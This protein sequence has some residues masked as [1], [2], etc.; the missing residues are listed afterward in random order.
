MRPRDCPDPRF[1]QSRVHLLIFAY[2]NPPL[3]IRKTEIGIAADSM[4][5]GDLTVGPGEQIA[6]VIGIEQAA[7]GEPTQHAAAYLLCHRSHRF[8][9]QCGLRGLDLSHGHKSRPVPWLVCL[10]CALLALPDD[11]ILRTRLA[12]SPPGCRSWPRGLSEYR[13]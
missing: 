8:W 6:G 3:G 4:R 7:A 9:R 13:Q 10:S 12:E 11:G 5:S 2:P 1:C